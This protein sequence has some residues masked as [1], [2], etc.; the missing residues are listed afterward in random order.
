MCL[1][2]L[3]KRVNAQMAAIGRYFLA[4][5]P[6]RYTKLVGMSFIDATRKERL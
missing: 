4:G 2:F 1:L 5:V 3:S 6:Q